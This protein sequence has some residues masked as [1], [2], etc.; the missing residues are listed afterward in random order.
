[1]LR[2]SQLRASAKSPKVGGSVSNGVQVLLTPTLDRSR[3]P[4]PEIDEATTIYISSILMFLFSVKSELLLILSPP[5]L[6]REI[7]RM[8]VV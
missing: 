8:N 1:M 4:A 3:N 6:M 2:N 5:R 7:F